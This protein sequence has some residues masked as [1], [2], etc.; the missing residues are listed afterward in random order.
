MHISKI[1]YLGYAFYRYKRKYRMRV[2]SKLVTK[3]QNKLRKL[4]IRGNKWSNKVR[5]EKLRS[6]A[7][8]WINYYRYRE[9][10]NHWGERGYNEY[11]VVTEGRLP[12][13]EAPEQYVCHVETRREILSV[14]V[15]CAEK[16]R[17]R[18]LLHL[19]HQ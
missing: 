12:F 3:M 10:Q 1:K 15:P 4:T 17:E 7:K 13:C 9:W 5:K 14:L 2:H 11:I 6:Y 19:Q 8:G 16:Q 18:F